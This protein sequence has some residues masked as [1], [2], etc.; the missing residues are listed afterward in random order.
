MTN[1]P[2]TGSG[3]NAESSTDEL[4]QQLH[5]LGSTSPP[6]PDP[7]FANRLETDLRLLAIDTQG[8]RR[9]IWRPVLSALAASVL[10][11][12]GVFS[13]MRLNPTPSDELVMSAAHQT[14]LVLPDGT[15][16]VA[17]DGTY[18]IDG[19]RI[20]VGRDGGAVIGSLVLLPGTVAVV[21]D[22]QIEILGPPESGEPVDG[23]SPSTTTSPT[24]SPPT[25]TIETS[26]PT[27]TGRTDDEV[28]GEAEPQRT[29]TTTTGTTSTAS[30]SSTTTTTS[31]QP[32]TTGPRLAPGGPVSP[33]LQVETVSDRRARLIW[34]VL[35]D[36]QIAGWVIM[37]E[38][39]DMTSTVAVLRDPEA[40]QVTVERPSE[41]VIN[42]WVVA[43]DSTGNV[44]HLSNTVA[45]TGLG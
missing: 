25:T 8:V 43:K 38:R 26:G 34:T 31:V 40:R 29:T 5:R 37:S 1:D 28:V 9:P 32:S 35:D 13:L 44:R 14:S 4:E 30:D 41:G 42:Y 20:V 6:A 18:L 19:T 27:T 12:V 22:G 16:V 21:V 33:V 7:A 3:D 2:T 15:E 36:D 39:D 45:V 17:S 23:G 10:V 24:T 11:M